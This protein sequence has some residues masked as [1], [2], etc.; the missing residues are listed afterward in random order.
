[1]LKRNSRVIEEKENYVIK[2]EE[3][4]TGEG[5]DWAK[6]TIGYTKDGEYIGNLKIT[7]FLCEQKGLS[8]LEKTQEEHCVCSIGFNETE[9]KWYGWSHRAITG[10]G[11]GSEVKKGDCAYRSVDQEESI[12]DALRFW[13]GDSHEDVKA[14]EV[15]IEE[16]ILGVWIEWKYSND[17][18][19]E[20]IRGVIGSVHW[21]FPE[22]YGK[23][24]WKADTL[25][26]AKQMAIDFS[27]DVS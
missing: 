18:E 20:K 26:D 1:M 7:E 4:C 10:F 11:I 8:K 19:N 23:G 2:E 13:S 5:L 21:S 24:E 22:Q 14:G 16:G 15:T 27:D 25:E 3:W 12:D 9:Q 17:V 6:M